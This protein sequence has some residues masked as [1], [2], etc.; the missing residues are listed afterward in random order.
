MQNAFI[1]NRAEEFGQ[2]VW[3]SYV[4]PLYFSS[5][6]LNEQRKSSVLEGGRGCG[7]TALLRYL[8]YQSQFSQTRSD[9]PEEALQT[10]GLYLK[11]DAQYFSGFLGAGL[12]VRKWQDIFEHALCLALAEQIVGAVKA[13]NSNA[14]RAELY[15]DI[16]KL[17]FL[18]AV[19]GFVEDGVPADIH[20]F[21]HWLRLQRQN[22]SRWF[23]N[24]GQE[25]PSK[26][27]P[28]REFLS[29]MIEEIQA[30]LSYMADSVFAVYL[31]EYENL[32]DYQ[33][34]FLNTLIKSG[35]P[36]LIFHVAMKPNG[37]RTRETS[38][39]ES[40]QDTADF[41]LIK[42][43]DEI[44]PYFK[45]FAAELFFF[46]L[47][48]EAGVSEN[49]TPILLEN[50]RRESE[51][52]SRI[53]DK[54]YHQRVLSAMD[55]ILPGMRYVD[56]AKG[57]LTR[58]TALFRRWQKIVKAGLDI[59][60]SKLLPGDF[61]DIDFP[62]ASVVCASLLH[63][64]SKSP[65]EILVEFR[66]YK[67]GKSSSFKEG[68]W[69]H[70]LVAGTLLLIYLPFRQKPCPMYAGFEAFAKLSGTSSRYF[71]ELCHL[72]IGV[73]TSKQSLEQFSVSVDEQA[74]AAFTASRKF[75]N[76]VSGCGDQGNRLLA[77][78]NFL[79][80]LFRLSQARF[81]QS[82][83]ER[84]HFSILNEELSGESKEV[85]R[86]A[87]KWSVLF[88]MPETKVKTNRYESKDYVLNPIFAPFFGLSYN[89]GRKL[90]L[91]SAHAKTM[92]AGPIDEFTQLL[93]QYEGKWAV[94]PD[95]QLHL[96]LEG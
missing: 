71:L 16:E 84:T 19:G 55:R 44:R 24:F 26:I 46:R 77:V 5:L 91:Q 72:S 40:I 33:Q 35:E 41:R 76:E 83:A 62:D 67:A 4:L 66:K 53:S 87:V 11:A 25:S 10:I 13:L 14:K 89:K 64:Q 31:D 58:E 32:L 49:E 73:F 7:K 50:L 30:K 48:L 12:D 85:L 52:V 23:K 95:D 74:D 54:Q 79:G 3:A 17:D 78:V 43:D 59:H 22:L 38:G 88:E 39:L 75:R 34:R 81:S 86:E 80:K 90:E 56:I 57:V 68:E 28:L 15:G 82:E 20:A 93:R 36:P 60:K 61:L 2:D 9:I 63:Q 70:H 96:E 45:I 69:I 27:L 29:A 18:S 8:S 1:R 94:V 65:D 6:G 92:L 42:L 21:E 47:I 37:M 51:I